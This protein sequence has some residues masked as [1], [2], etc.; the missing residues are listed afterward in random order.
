PIPPILL[1]R[2]LDGSQRSTAVWDSANGVTPSLT[3]WL[4]TTVARPESAADQL[5]RPSDRRLTRTPAV[6]ATHSE[7]P[8]GATPVT[9]S[10]GN[11]EGFTPSGSTPEI[12]RP[13]HTPRPR[14]VPIHIEAPH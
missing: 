8:S 4:T 10:L 11:G 14:R 2:P 3:R 6:V 13:A 7:S 5:V 1:Q 9:A 12:C